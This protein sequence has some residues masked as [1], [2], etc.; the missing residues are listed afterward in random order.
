MNNIEPT[1]EV[2]EPEEE[3]EEEEIIQEKPKR[4][5]VV[6]TPE[7]LEKKRASIKRALLAKQNKRENM[8]NELE[9]LQLKV[10]E[11]EKKPIY[12]TKKT[13][14]TNELKTEI[15]ELKNLIISLQKPIQQPK[16]MKPSMNELINGSYKEQLRNNLE[17][18]IYKKSMNEL[19]DY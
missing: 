8:K 9:A 14:E 11:Q 4:K 1:D 12:N 17:Q 6:Y 19:F 16:Q 10:K 13:Q 5:P 2:N 15:Q 3:Q 18:N 7:Q